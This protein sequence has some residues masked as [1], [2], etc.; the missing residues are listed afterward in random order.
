[1]ATPYKYNPAEMPAEDLEATFVGRQHLLDRLITAVREQ[2]DAG[3]IQH[4]LLLGPRGIGKTTLLLMLYR[5]IK[6][7][8]ELSGR[9]FPIRYREEEFYVY[10]LRDLL[11]LALEHL[12][13]EE[14]VPEAETIR[15]EAEAEDDDEQSMAKLLDGLRKITKSYKKRLL[16]LIDN[17]DQ[18]FPGRAANDLDQHA[19][20][21]LLSTESFLMVVGTSTLLFED[22]F[23][24]DEAFFNFFAPIPVENLSDEEIQDLLYRW[25]TL[26]ENQNFLKEYEQLKEK[27]RAITYLTGGNP[28]LVMM[29]Y[30]ILSQRQF[31]SVV[32]TLR[33]T[34][35]DLTPLLKDVLEDLPRQQ[36][37]V[38]DALMRLGGTASPSKIAEH[39]RLPLNVV[40]TQVGRLKGARRI[41]VQGEGRGKP[42]V[43]RVS[44]QMFRT[45]YQ[46]RYLRPARRRVEMFVEFLQAWFTVEDR[47]ASLGQLRKEFETSMSSGLQRRAKETAFNMEY[48]AASL[49]D[50]SERVR[51][52]E[53]VADAY[54][55]VG[56]VREAALTLSDLRAQTIRSKTRYEAVG[57]AALGDRLLDKGD[58]SR[59]I[60]TYS[61]ALKKDKNNLEARMGLGLAL[62]MSGDH[63]KA[64]KEFSVA[65]E[66]RGISVG[67]LCHALVSRGT[68][69]GFLGDTEG[70]IADYTSVIEM[71]GAPPD[72]V[73]EALNNWGVMKGQLGDTEG[74]IAD[75]TKII[76]MQDV[77]PDLMAMVLNNR[78]LAKGKINDLD[79]T[80]VDFTE[81]LQIKNASPEQAAKALYN[82][83]VSKIELDDIKGALIDFNA[84][85]EVEGVPLEQATQALFNRGFCKSKLNDFEG[86][87]TD[88]T[89]ILMFKKISPRQEAEALNNR[90]IVKGMLS[91]VEGSIEDY[92]KVLEIEGVPEDQVAA[93][94]FSRGV[95]KG[96]LGNTEDEII[97]YTAVLKVKGALPDQVGMALYNRGV[98][99]GRLGDREGEIIDYTKSAESQANFRVVHQ[100]L[101]SLI[102]LLCQQGRIDESNRWMA[103]M[104]E[105]EP[106]GTPAEQRL[107]ARIGIIV[108]VA[109]TCSLN[110]ATALLDTLLN[111]A[112]SDLRERLAFL[113]P[114]LIFA[115]NSDESSL[116]KLPQEEQEMARRIAATV[117][118]REKKESS[119]V[120]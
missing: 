64:L 8:P 21:K 119:D 91:N 12:Y 41:E 62:G 85:L 116:A 101:R 39:A 6:E 68:A 46:M 71:K 17:F 24:Y 10:T 23:S 61:E 7:D 58:L 92:T 34:I 16:L 104:D 86:A 98:S 50:S 66:T 45:W 95:A 69:K 27:V 19:F 32:Q 102:Q 89:T 77:S 60:Q 42:A 120:E 74:A 83:G 88:Y 108:T 11:A 49:D 67:D 20:R 117:K 70:E 94:L 105:L 82:R 13:E 38:L 100:G 118:K 90:G 97:D 40:T 113:K 55:A 1:M 37:K 35:D 63:E 18:F 115:Q 76:E 53:G 112:P 75:F 93:A 109:Q 111:T 48:L 31:L 84:V 65:T 107:E 5:R 96:V 72:Q 44:D 103:R 47:V 114:G 36:S 78:G 87:I 22:I 4:Y 59:A 51:Q 2:T 54:M 43:C 81:V 33:E 110:V 52:L 73:A 26:D 15:H 25:A 9:W 57:Y 28:R 99:K 56:E 3:S 106:E 14:G 29:L 30:E 80:I 79:G